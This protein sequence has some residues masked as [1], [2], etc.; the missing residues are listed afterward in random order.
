MLLI[1]YPS[2][3]ITSGKKE[4]LGRFLVVATGENGEKCVPDVS[5]LEGFAGTVIHSIDYESGKEFEGKKVLVV[6]CGN[7]GAGS[8]E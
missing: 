3:R 7:S 8:C 5:G 1:H 2:L 6:G 4:Y